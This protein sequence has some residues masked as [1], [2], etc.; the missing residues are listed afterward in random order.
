LARNL[1]Q[2]FGSFIATLVVSTRH[3][4]N[5]P[6]LNCLKEENELRY[7]KTHFRH[8]AFNHHRLHF[9][10]NGLLNYWWGL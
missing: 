6:D 8:F 9:L 7:E 1:F 4:L 3:K 10:G 5:K 2:E